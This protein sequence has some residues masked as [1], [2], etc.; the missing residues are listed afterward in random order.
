[1]SLIILKIFRLT[2]QGWKAN[3]V[4]PMG[5]QNQNSAVI[6]TPA[7]T[8]DAPKTFKFDSSTDLKSELEKVN[9]QVSDSDFE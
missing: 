9:P 7:P 5:Q 3:L 8:P 4:N 1:M 2:P 6:S